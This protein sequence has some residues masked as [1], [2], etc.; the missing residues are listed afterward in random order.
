MIPHVA[1]N[2]GHSP[3]THRRLMHILEDRKVSDGVWWF[4]VKETT[5]ELDLDTFLTIVYCTVDELYQ[6]Q[7]AAAK[8]PR[9]GT[10]P[11]LSD[12]EVLTLLLLTQWHPSRSERAVGRYAAAHPF[13]LVL[14]ETDRSESLRCTGGRGSLSR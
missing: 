10:A 12:S 14:R 6:T 9:P 5:M 2:M 8:P 13:V 4:L 11:T 1:G 7:F 3:D